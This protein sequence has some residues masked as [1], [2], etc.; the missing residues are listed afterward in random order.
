MQKYVD[1]RYKYKS[2][3]GHIDLMCIVR[4]L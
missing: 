3:Y 1:I 2:V 4:L